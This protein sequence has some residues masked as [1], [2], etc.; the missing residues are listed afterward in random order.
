M[1]KL[2]GVNPSSNLSFIQRKINTPL[3][4]PSFNLMGL[5]N[6]QLLN[7][8]MFSGGSSGTNT[9]SFDNQSNLLFFTLHN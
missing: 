4:N 9:L 2:E 3:L 7:H 1:N 8:S 6:S 5:T